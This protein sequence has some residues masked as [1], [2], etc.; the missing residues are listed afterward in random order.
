MSPKIY[1]P[2]KLRR[3]VNLSFQ[4]LVIGCFSIGIV[5]TAYSVY[6]LTK[7]YIFDKPIYKRQ[8]REYEEAL[9]RKEKREKELGLRD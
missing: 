1:R 6:G 2:S 3:F 4:G 9:Y 8:R 7:Y 5:I